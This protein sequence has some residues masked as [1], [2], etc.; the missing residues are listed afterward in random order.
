MGYLNDVA[1][2]DT[3]QSLWGNTVRDRTVTPYDSIAQRDAQAH[4]LEGMLCT[5]AADHRLWRYQSGR[6][7]ILDEPWQGWTVTGAIGNTP[8]AVQNDWAQNKMTGQHVVVQ[9][10][11]KILNQGYSGGAVY[12]S[13]PPTRGNAGP[14][15]MPVGN[16]TATLFAQGL[17]YPVYFCTEFGR[18]F[19]RK[20]SDGQS[21]APAPGGG[22]V[23]FIGTFQYQ[24]DSWG[25]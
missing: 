8:I 12:F 20:M 15:Q 13:L 17:T 16:G 10:A 3:I 4:P 14:Q 9:W 24:S 25:P 6:W 23:Y 21:V 7:T 18:V 11:V 1:P 5:T 19:A 22:D 2:F